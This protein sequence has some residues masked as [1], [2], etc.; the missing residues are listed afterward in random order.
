MEKVDQ[1]MAQVLRQKSGA[2]RLAIAHEMFESAR[3]MLK[4][5]LTAEHPDWN[6][7]QIAQ[8][9]ARRLSHGAG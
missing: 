7:E 3:R 4:A 8:E 5:H 6:E 9:V 2:E 1:E